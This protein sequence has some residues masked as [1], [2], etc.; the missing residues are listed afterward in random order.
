MKSD[1]SLVNTK[2]ESDSEGIS[3]ME[4]TEELGREREE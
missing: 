1:K 2:Y 4:K 3:K